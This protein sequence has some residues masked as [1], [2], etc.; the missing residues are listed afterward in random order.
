MRLTT[1]WFDGQE[2]LALCQ[3]DGIIR[4]GDLNREFQSQWPQAMQELIETGGLNRLKDW[5]NQQGRRELDARK[6]LWKNRRQ[7]SFAPPYRFPGKIWGIGLNYREH[8]RDLS[9]RAPTSAPASFM[10]PY[11]TIIG[12]GE[13]IEIPLLSQRTTAEAELGIIIGQRCRHVPQH[14]WLDVVAGF[15][16]ILDMTAEDILVQNPRFLTMSKSFDTF[17]SFGP[18]VL[19]AEELGDIAGL[20][21]STVINGKV[22]AENTIDHMTFTPDALV[23]YHSQV[24]TLLPGDIISTGTP[25]AVPIHHGDI[26]QCRITGFET[27]E[28]P[29]VDLKQATG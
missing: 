24:M 6:H 4:I 21:V 13:P 2:Q 26:V 14:K 10:K 19:T 29:V 1:I 15:T 17:F 16:T 5:Y 9:E 12:T 23:A 7:C 28:N 3:Q 18:Q 11:T 20:K 27:L 8:A 22:H 25:S